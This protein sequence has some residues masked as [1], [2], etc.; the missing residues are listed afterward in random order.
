MR[1]ILAACVLVVLLFGLYEKAQRGNESAP[2]ATLSTPAPTTLAETATTQSTTTESPAT[3]DAQ[4]AREILGTEPAPTESAL[5]AVVVIID[6]INAP[7]QLR[8]ID[9]IPLAITPAIM[10]NNATNPQSSEL[11]KNREVYLVHLPL[12]AHNFVQRE[13]IV[14]T[15]SQSAESI[16]KRI[17]DIVAQFPNVRFL[18]SHTGSKFTEHADSMRALLLALQKHEILFLDSKTTSKSVAREVAESL[19]LRIL[20]RDV[21]LD[22]DKKPQKIA[23]QLHLAVTIAKK[24][25]YAIAIGHPYP[26]TFSVLSQPQWKELGVAFVYLDTLVKE[27]I[28]R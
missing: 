18:N 17:A 23:K 19:G 12:Q 5:P 4:Q 9:A 7:E 25:G 1:F 22:F 21:F 3:Q 26:E 8:K 27:K 16:A 11:H 10:P 20:E 15:D 2:V 24:R 28:W 6:D 13:H 14:L